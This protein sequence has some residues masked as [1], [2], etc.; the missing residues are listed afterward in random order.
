MDGEERRP[1]LSRPPLSP[2]PLLSAKRKKE[3][4]EED[5][6]EEGIFFAFA[7]NSFSIRS[8]SFSTVRA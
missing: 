3:E 7:V 6:D 8:R 4:E 5:E 2:L 1:L